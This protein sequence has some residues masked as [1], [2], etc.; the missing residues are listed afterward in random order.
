MN[1]FTKLIQRLGKRSKNTPQ[2]LANDIKFSSLIQ[3]IQN[4]IINA[5]A[6]L[7]C[8]GLE[9]IEQFFNKKPKPDILKKVNYK[10][11][12][13]EEIL[14]TGAVNSASNLLTDLKL[15]I[16]ELSDPSKGQL[17]DYSPKM[18]SFEVPV[19]RN[20]LW[21]VE[22]INVPLLTLSPIV[23]PKIKQLT[24]TSNVHSLYQDDEELYVRMP[25]NT[26]ANKKNKHPDDAQTSE[27]VISINPELSS[28][29]LN[30]VIAHYKQILNSNNTHT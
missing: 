25:Q 17:N 19:Y 20:G 3:Q 29:E 14:N 5:N 23:L 15:D 2:R 18:T 11:N 30:D 13:I 26:Y 7:E 1:I 4:D 22:C 24:F 12:A 21:G 10:L 27:L 16:D 28:D 9:Y 8:V 6:S